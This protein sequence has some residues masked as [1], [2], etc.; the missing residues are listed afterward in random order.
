MEQHPKVTLCIPHQE[1]MVA[2]FVHSLIYMLGHS[3]WIHQ[4]SWGRGS[5]SA[6]ARNFCVQQ[7][8][9]K[10]TEWYLFIDSDMGF[11]AQTL[12]ALL[13]RGK[14]M[15]SAVCFQKHPPYDPCIYRYNSIGELGKLFNFPESEVFKIDGTGGAMMLVKA[16]IFDKMSHHNSAWHNHWWQWGDHHSEDLTFCL[17]AAE[18][19][20]E[21][22]CDS[23]LVIDH[24]TN[25]PRGKE[26]YYAVRDKL[27]QAE[28][29]HGIPDQWPDGTP[30]DYAKFREEMIIPDV[31]AADMSR[32]TGFEK[33]VDSAKDGNEN[34]SL[35]ETE[36]VI[37]HS[38]DRFAGR[39]IRLKNFESLQI[40]NCQPLTITKEK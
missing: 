9:P 27:H 23:S 1:M 6:A 4:I 26:N 19:G 24:F 14:R 20:E 25:A 30:F 21:V 18:V 31:V 17:R 33:T 16:E 10:T 32:L 11:P 28:K 12:E 15:I 34:G 2:E 36:E 5:D 35:P 3:Y 8:P 7:Y 13:S 22:W 40:R 38:L 29:D 39:G 37:A